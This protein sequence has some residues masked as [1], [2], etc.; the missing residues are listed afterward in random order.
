MVPF[1]RP[2]PLPP[3]FYLAGSTSSAMFCLMKYLSAGLLALFLALP[4]PGADEPKSKTKLK[5]YPL[6]KCVVS[7]E[8]FGGD[9][10][11]PYVFEHEGREVKLCCKS[12]LKD[13]KKEPAKY[14]KKMDSAEKAKK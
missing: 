12:C 7:D 8:A 1:P 2:E 9:M 4:L 3:Y 13:F 5:P 14:L 11:P 10:G 6:S